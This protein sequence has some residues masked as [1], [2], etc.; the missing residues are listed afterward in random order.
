MGPRHG[1]WTVTGAGDEEGAAVG[2]AIIVVGALGLR[3]EL[4]AT[5]NSQITKIMMISPNY[6][7]PTVNTQTTSRIILAG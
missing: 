7:L 2:A 1:E 4:M 5:T 6:H 3:S